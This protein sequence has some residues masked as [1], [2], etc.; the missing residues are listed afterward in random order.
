MNKK[1][2]LSLAL[3]VIMIATISFSS[4]AWFTDTDSAKNEFTIGGAEQGDPDQIFSVEVKEYVDGEN[5]PVD[6]MDFEK[7][8][9]GD[10]FKKE[11]FITNPGAYEQYIRVTIKIS[12]WDLVKDLITVN[13]ANDFSEN[14]HIVSQ[15]V[16]VNRSGNLTVRGNNSVDREGNLVVVMYLDH[17]LQPEERETVRIMDYVQI[18]KNATQQ[19]F[20]KAQFIDGFFIDIKAEAA[21]T[22][23]IL[24]DYRDVRDDVDN[25]I[26]TFAALDA[27]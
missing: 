4:L 12:D 21:Q 27:E 20:G 16:S 15:G 3:V 8:L 14:W 22:E 19:D 10:T 5:D 11:A 25:A 2:L 9:P 26:Q 13:M 17:K 6:N 23:N 24:P 1:K 7:I 18:S